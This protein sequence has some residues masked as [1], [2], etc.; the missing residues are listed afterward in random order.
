MKPRVFGIGLTKTGTSTLGACLSVLGYDHFGWR[1]GLFERVHAGHLDEAFAIADRHES[2]DDWPWPALYREMDDRFPD[3]RFVLTVRRDSAGW[4]DSLAAHARRYEPT[5]QRR[6][7]FGCD[8]P[9]DDRGGVITRYERHNDD[10]AR[11]FAG[12]PGK[13]LEICW[14]RG[15]GWSELCG[16]L[17]VPIPDEPLPHEHRRPV[18][19]TLFQMRRLVRRFRR[20]SGM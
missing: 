11:H 14:E 8:D 4:F 19:L 10:V 20:W 16:F 13:L 5:E 18:S 6:L 7:A 12:R 3:A 2:F 1:K 15:D 17:G 9:R